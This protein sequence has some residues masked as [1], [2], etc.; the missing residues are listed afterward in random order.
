MYG[1]L[2]CKEADELVLKDEYYAN[3]AKCQLWYKK[4]REFRI[5][6]ASRG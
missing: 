4:R 2:P 5:D 6:L 3:S 1:S